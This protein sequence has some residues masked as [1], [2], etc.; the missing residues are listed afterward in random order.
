MKNLYFI[1]FSI[2]LF[3]FFVS[4][5]FISKN[6]ANAETL[7]S[8][9]TTSSN[10][11]LCTST[12]NAKGNCGIIITKDV[13]TINTLSFYVYNNGT[14]SQTEL[15]LYN[16]L[17]GSILIG[18]AFAT[19]TT[20]AGY[21][22]L[23]YSFNNLNVSAYEKIY[24]GFYNQSASTVG[25]RVV[26]SNLY[27]FGATSPYD[28]LDLNIPFYYYY[29]SSSTYFSNLP[30]SVITGTYKQEIVTD[31]AVYP[32][33]YPTELNQYPDLS[34]DFSKSYTY[35]GSSTEPIETTY[36]FKY[37]AWRQYL[38]ILSLAGGFILTIFT[39]YFLIKKK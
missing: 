12:N 23:N 38:Y 37:S 5:F 25:P 17:N 33:E 2:F 20:P 18:N 30:I 1:K 39:F 13:E 27:N 10:N 6:T 19:T 28:F 29:T 8:V 14:N 21:S 11:P 9:V 15:R 26:Y 36:S 4:I 24:L 3:I 7:Y 34:I 22:T 16:D 35:S 32:N 31:C